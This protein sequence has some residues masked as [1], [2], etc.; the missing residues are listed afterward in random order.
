[1]ALFSGALQIKK[2]KLMIGLPTFIS[3]S[4]HI[5]DVSVPSTDSVEL[6]EGEL[7]KR[8]SL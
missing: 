8:V 2:V 4:F 3:S 5:V 6:P 7:L 1:M